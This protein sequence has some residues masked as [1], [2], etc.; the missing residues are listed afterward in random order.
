M[1]VRNF[2]LL[3]II[4][5]PVIS[6]EHAIGL[7]SSMDSD[8][9]HK[10]ETWNNDLNVS[11]ITRSPNILSGN[12]GFSPE[13]IGAGIESLFTGIVSI[14]NNSQIPLTAMSY[15]TNDSSNAAAVILSYGEHYG[16]GGSNVFSVYRLCNV[17]Q[18]GFCNSGPI[19]GFGDLS[20]TLFPNEAVDIS[21]DVPGS[22]QVMRINGF[23]LDPGS[24]VLYISN[25]PNSKAI[26]VDDSSLVCTNLNSDLLDGLHASEIFSGTATYS[27]DSDKVDGLH[28]NEVFNTT[29]KV[30]NAT[31]SDDS[32]KLD[33]HHWNEIPTG[34][35]FNDTGLL[36]QNGTR[37]LTG[38]WDTGQFNITTSKINLTVATGTAPITVASTTKVTNL[39]AD[40]CDGYDFNQDVSYRASYPVFAGIASYGGNSINMQSATGSNVWTLGTDGLIANVWFASSSGALVPYSANSYSVGT[41]GN[42]WNKMYSE[43]YYGKNTSIIAFDDY[44]DTS[45]MKSIVKEGE[46]FKM[47]NETIDTFEENVT[48]EEPWTLDELFNL[49]NTV[50][51][52]KYVNKTI[53][54]ES[55]NMG[56]VQGL[57][58][59]AI[60]ELITKTEGLEA[61]NQRLKEQ[62]TNICKENDLKG[63]T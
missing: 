42:Y 19:A 35:S 12:T 6:I 60:K 25:T 30:D 32:D 23:F 2:L 13:L 43:T 17:S 4:L 31:Y 56:K 48:V 1:N 14:S 59:G 29:I 22:Y 55:L 18:S 5:I 52:P 27:D 53:T 10:W 49:N 37:Q 54:T 44:D 34:S 50:V 51:E 15:A 46:Y 26:E 24:K 20:N 45:L 21:S 36:Y 33:G 57:T 38:N 39:N 16:G 58:I 3:A 47:P 61:E 41:S 7:G 40:K 9:V 63:C 62:I 11:T 28:A 8:A